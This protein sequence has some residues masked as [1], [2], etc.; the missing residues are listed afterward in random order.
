M[1]NKNVS[2]TYLVMAGFVVQRMIR[3][4]REA[5]EFAIDHDLSKEADIFDKHIEKLEYIFGQ[6]RKE[7]GYDYGG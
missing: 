3:L 7:T 4:N 6:I 5:I 1:V 2:R